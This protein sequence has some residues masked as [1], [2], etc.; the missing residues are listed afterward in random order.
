MPPVTSIR[1]WSLVAAWFSLC[2]LQCGRRAA[3]PAAAQAPAPPVT[4][5]TSAASTDQPKALTPAGMAIE[6]KEPALPPNIMPGATF[7]LLLEIR[8]A[9]REEWPA[10]NS[11]PAYREGRYAVRLSH[12]WCGSRGSDCPQFESRHELTE[13]MPPGSS[14]TLLLILTAPAKPGLYELQFDVVQELVAW[15]S[16]HHS[17][18]LVI[19][20]RV[21]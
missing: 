13:S 17:R 9:G 6:W 10:A 3:D 5:T 7:T 21:G 11:S 1:R 8:N 18:P 2:V 14:Q 12:R 16:Q 15:F 19:P 20:V 4:T